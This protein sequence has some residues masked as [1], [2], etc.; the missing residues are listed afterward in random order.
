MRYANVPRCAE[1]ASPKE[2]V[3]V[4]PGNEPA[5][6]Q[7]NTG[8]LDQDE[9]AELD[10]LRA[11]NKLLRTERDVLARVATGLVEDTNASLLR[12]WMHRGRP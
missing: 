9:R 11:E 3:T 7:D 6:D 2:A 5:T 4:M 8:P 1:H 10:W 12:L